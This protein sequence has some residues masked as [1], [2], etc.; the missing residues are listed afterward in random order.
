MSVSYFEKLIVL[1]RK[2]DEGIENLQDAWQIP[3][4][5]VGGCADISDETRTTIESLKKSI[6]CTQD[7]MNKLV[8]ST[9]L[10]GAIDDMDNIIRSAQNTYDTV[11]QDVDNLETVF[12]EYGYCYKTDDVDNSICETKDIAVP[13]TENMLIPPE[14]TMLD[15]TL[16]SVQG[17]KKC[18][19]TQKQFL[20]PRDRPED[21]IY[22][23]HFYSALKKKTNQ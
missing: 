6:Q 23:K 3:R 4:I 8:L 12:E 22:S 10:A 21:T 19:E 17:T 11:K 15:M 5:F 1:A 9:E 16:P 13:M 18:S 7:D 2:L 14:S 20:T